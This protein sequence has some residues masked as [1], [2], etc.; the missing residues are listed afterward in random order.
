M[1]YKK[2]T[3]ILATLSLIGSTALVS[4]AETTDQPHFSQIDLN[5]DNFISKAELTTQAK[6]LFDRT[7]ANND[8]ALSIIELMVSRSAT[9]SVR[10]Q[11]MID[12]A[13]KNSDGLVNFEELEAARSQSLRGNIFDKL[14]ANNDGQ[15]SAEEFAKSKRKH[16]VKGNIVAKL[17][18]TKR[19]DIFKKLDTDKD[20]QLGAE[21]KRDG[22]SKLRNKI[23]G[24][25]LDKLQSLNKDDAKN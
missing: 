14:D 5:G 19:G 7:D 4:A 6:T 3:K 18:S 23:R 15:L 11:K 17:K 16:D 24:K 1:R 9:A 2:S 8:G 12:K 20:G 13:D 25:L 10:L 21:E 22:K